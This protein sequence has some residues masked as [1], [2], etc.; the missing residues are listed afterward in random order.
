MLRAALLGLAA[1]LPAGTA[2]AQ[3]AND[4]APTARQSL[5]FTDGTKI[6]VAYRQLA[7][8]GGNSF[9]SLMTK[10]ARGAGMRRIY[11]ERYLPQHLA[12][13]LELS[14]AMV[15]GG[16]ELAAG[17]YGFTFRIDENLAWHF[18]VQKDGKDVCDLPLPAK[19]DTAQM[20]SRLSIQPIATSHRESSGYLAIAYGP[21]AAQVE[22]A[23][24]GQ[25]GAEGAPESQPAA[26][27]KSGQRR[28]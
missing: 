6:E 1:V 24:A 21:L 8:G 22:F 13:K 7:L 20:S 28:I 10:D 16:H 12:G 27:E 5:E 15:L 14:R 11:N 17:A 23:P 19:S 4:D 2:R 18:V 25:R 9:K 3:N 26:H